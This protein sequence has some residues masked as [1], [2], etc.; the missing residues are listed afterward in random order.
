MSHFPILKAVEHVFL[1]LTFVF[2]FEYNAVPWQLKTLNT[3][4]LKR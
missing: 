3:V 1:N 2:A 4:K